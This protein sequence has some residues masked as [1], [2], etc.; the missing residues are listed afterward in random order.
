MYVLEFIEPF[1][2]TLYFQRANQSG[3]GAGRVQN[4][5]T[6]Q[7]NLQQ[8]NGTYQNNFQPTAG[9]PTYYQ[10]NNGA[11]YM[12]RNG[13]Q[14]ING[15]N[16]MPSITNT[17]RPQDCVSFHNNNNYQ[18]APKTSAQTEQY[19]SY[20]PPTSYQQTASRNYQTNE[21]SWSPVTNGN[22]GFNNEMMQQ[23]Q[24]SNNT[25]QNSAAQYFLSD[26]LMDKVQA[27]PSKKALLELQIGFEQLLLEP[28]E[29]DTWANVIRDRL[30]GKDL[31]GTYYNTNIL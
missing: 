15:Q 20:N 21:P 10:A 8:S 4:S 28:T 24:N 3:A 18:Q 12:N 31:S 29:F 1:K 13:A 30:T 11:Y 19:N 25:P 6:S 14:S 2:L 22:G 5:P 23:A 27:S 16:G 17:T 26:E 9:Q 7:A